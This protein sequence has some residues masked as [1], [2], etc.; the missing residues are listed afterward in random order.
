MKKVIIT[1]STGFIGKWLMKELIERNVEVIA[2]IRQF[3]LDD[4]QNNDMKIR[5]IQY[6]SE[7]YLKLSKEENIDIFFHLA[8][9]GVAPEDK[10]NSNLQIEN[11]RLSIEMLEFAAKLHVS[12]FVATGTVAEY[13]F[14]K[15]V[16]DFN[17]KQTPNDMYGAAKTA[18]HYML[19]TR[20]RQLGVPFIWSVLP[21]TYGE[22]RRD[23][24]I[25]TYTIQTLLRGEKPSYGYLTQM[26]DFLYVK[27]VARALYLIGEKGI[28]G[29]TYGIGSGEY[30]QLKEYIT[31]I[32]DLID[33]DLPI[34]IGDNP[35]LS[36]KTFSSCVNI[37]DLMRDTGFVPSISFEEGINNAIEYYRRKMKIR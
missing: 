22:G 28:V 16:M 24:N 25:I 13:A 34:G 9:G 31:I 15:D 14:C 8:W 21:S 33:K 36:Q 6:Y 5:Y 10:D 7:D 1:G 12:K 29:K 32:R 2:L 27:E 30:R 23:R 26:W 19:E 4:Q 37:S 17:E 18:A 11:I 20:A 35:T 3:P